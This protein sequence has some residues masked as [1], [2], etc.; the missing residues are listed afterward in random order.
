MNTD[1]DKQHKV[2]NIDTD[3]WTP[4]QVARWLQQQV[5]DGR[6]ESVYV[7][8]ERPDDDDGMTTYITSWSVNTRQGLLYMMSWAYQGLLR[9]YFG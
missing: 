5:D 1:D 9:R 3:D 2:V 8:V 7:V 6:V 4:G